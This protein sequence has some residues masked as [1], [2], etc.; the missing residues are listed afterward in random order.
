M[1]LE[2][3]NDFLQAVILSL[4]AFILN[5]RCIYNTEFVK[6]EHQTQN[7]QISQMN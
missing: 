6:Y 2:A 4:A 7:Q 1:F 3:T 5:R